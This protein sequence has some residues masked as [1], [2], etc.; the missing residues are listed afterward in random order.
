MIK[1]VSFPLSLLL[2][3]T[4]CYIVQDFSRNISLLRL[5]MAVVGIG[6]VYVLLQKTVTLAGSGHFSKIRLG[7]GVSGKQSD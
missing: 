1:P 4:A 5:D 7:V 6:T 2:C 3:T